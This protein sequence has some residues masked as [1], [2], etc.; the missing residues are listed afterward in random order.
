MAEILSPGIFVEEIPSTQQAVTAVSTSNMGIVGATQRGPTN[1]PTL[2]TSF[3]QFQ[4]LFGPIIA[5]SRLG[6]SMAAYYANGGK[7]AFVVRVMP[8][9]AEAANADL[10]TL[11]T[12]FQTNTGD[13]VTATVDDTVLT[14]VALTLPIAPAPAASVSFEWRAAA[15]AVVAEG[16]TQ[17]DGVTPLLGNGATLVFAGRIA[18]SS[19]ETPDMDLHVVDGG[20]ATF[21]IDAGGG[22]T[23]VLVAAGDTATGT[24]GAGSTATIDLKTGFVHMVW[25]VAETPT[26]AAITIDYTPT[27]ATR[28]IFDDGSG[29]LL[30]GTVLTGAGSVNYDTG[31][32]SFTTT[33][34]ATPHDGGAIRATFKNPTFGTDPN[35]VGTWANEMRMDVRG[36]SDFYDVTTNTYSRFDVNVLLVNPDNDEF[37]VVETYEEITFTDTLDSQYFPDVVNDLSDL[38]TVDE[39]AYYSEAPAQLNGI[40]RTQIIGAGNEVA[41][42]KNL[43]GT[44]RHSPFSARS[45]SITFTADSDLSTKTITDNGAGVLIGDVDPAGT[46]TVNYNTG[47]FDVTLSEPADRST[48][49][50]ATFRSRA[51]ETTHSEVYGDTSKNYVDG[52]SV[53]HYEAGEDGTFNALNY[54]RDQF[55]SSALLEA[56]FE[57]IYAL[58]RVEE[59]MQVV[60][61][62]FAGD[63]TITKDII[64]YV[65]GRALQPSGGDR[66]AILT[67]PL[68][69]SAQEAVDFFRFDINQFSKFSAMYWP[70]VKIADPLANNRPLVFPPLG[71]L[72]GIYARTDQTR[73]VGKAPGG[74]VD[75]ALSYLLDLEMTPTQGE[76]DF[77][78]PNKIN[79]LISSPATGLAVWGVRT[80]AQE[81][82]WRY[83]NARRLFMFVEKSIYNATFWIVFENNGPALWAR[84][85]SQVSSFLNG[86]FSDGLLAGSSPSQ[87]FFV[88]VD[89]TNNTPETIDA[90]QVIIDVGI[91]PNK[92]A[93]FVRFRFTQKSL[94]T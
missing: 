85:K 23:I 8:A 66:F 33:V 35:S 63:V 50:T 42:G 69:S 43:V 77:V 83:I 12:R 5:D 30:A 54:G 60:I 3:P 9:N 65:N 93:E 31:V 75:G 91:A 64:D 80:I 18:I 38:V 11:R 59:L 92:P 76:R 19:L 82:E 79:P 22:F 53:E 55:T 26:A 40:A 72:A 13:G 84:I 88:I 37:E 27:T 51:V 94:T 48:F 2:V 56:D 15:A 21:E 14:P 58:N 39:P 78:Y 73:N 36:N 34:A 46:N 74:T 20:A 61:P 7:R 24:N 49:V 45:L 1:E 70:W 29:V 86:L 90:G 41:A 4:R 44:L 16:L 52:A 81:S 62:D 6:L 87:A 17:M 71:H 89:E 47:A 32:Y 25:A 68:G 67:V 57:G 10:Q 28:Q